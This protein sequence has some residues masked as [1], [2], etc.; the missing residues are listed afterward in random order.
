MQKCTG[1]FVRSRGTIKA[2]REGPEQCELE[3][4][5]A[6]VLKQKKPSRLPQEGFVQS[7]SEARKLTSGNLP[8]RIKIGAQREPLQLN[9]ISSLKARWQQPGSYRPQQTTS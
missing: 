6:A 4:P 5:S 2:F 1:G 9:R 7:G 3:A 8:D